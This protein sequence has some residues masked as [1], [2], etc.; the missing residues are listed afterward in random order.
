MFRSFQM[1]CISFSNSIFHYTSTMFLPITALFHFHQ[2]CDSYRQTLL[3]NY[4]RHTLNAI[5]VASPFDFD[6]AYVPLFII[7]NMFYQRNKTLIIREIPMSV[8][9]CLSLHRLNKDQYL[10]ASAPRYN[11]TRLSLRQLWIMLLGKQQI[12]S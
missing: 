12:S 10:C 3:T 5:T 11:T 9:Q 7:P 6:S 2:L 4:L 1:L 8:A